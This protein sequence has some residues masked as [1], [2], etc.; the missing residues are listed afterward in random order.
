M[1]EINI[2]GIAVAVPSGAE[3][4]P[5]WALLY[6]DEYVRRVTS[7]TGINQVR[8]SN[9]L[10]TS[11]LCSAAAS[12][13][14]RELSLSASNVDALIFVSQTPNAYMPA[15]SCQLQNELDLPTSA[16][17]IDVSLGCSGYPYALIL[18]ASLLTANKASRVLVLAGDVITP[19]IDPKD[20][21]TRMVFG[22]G[23]S[24]TLVTLGHSPLISLH[25]TDGSGAQSL[26]MELPD[27]SG[28]KS[29]LRMDGLDVM[30]F[31][32]SHVP[33]IVRTLELQTQQ[34]YGHPLETV[35][36]HQANSFIVE[37]LARTSKV[38]EAI[39]FPL[40]VDGFGNTGPASIPLA[41][42][43]QAVDTPPGIAG[44][45]GFGVGWSWAGVVTDLSF[46]RIVPLIEIPE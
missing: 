25:G 3:G 24:A 44:I 20:S 38:S 29:F 23:G 27:E 30:N 14:L 1:T 41:I 36:L 11:D 22:D 34:M 16:L 39:K 10:R 4:T 28:E 15:T 46:A 45:V 5:E 13:L 7:R 19:H 33:P 43:Q 26:H 35:F 40:H 32:L 21:A 8:K 2:E 12:S 17:A 9:K 42:C 18:A 31:A 37:T 6:G